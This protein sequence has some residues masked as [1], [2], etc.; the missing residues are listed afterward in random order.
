MVSRQ[1]LLRPDFS[2][3]VVTE[4]VQAPTDW[5]FREAHHTVVVHLAGQLQQME[6]VFS[7]GPSTDM[8]P[9]VGDCWVIPAG[10][11]YAALARGDQVSFVEFH[12][13]ADL[14]NAGEPRA[15]VGHRDAFLHQASLRLASLA[16]RT[17]DMGLMMQQ[18]LLDTLRLHL[19]DVLLCAGPSAP[20]RP[21]AQTFSAR[22]KGLLSDYIEAHVGG[23]ITVEALAAVT[24]QSMARFLE[25]FKTSFGTTPWQYVLRFRLAR[26]QHLLTSSSASI[27]A[28]ASAVGF[29][30]PSHFATAF[31]RLLGVS[32]AQ[33]RS[34][35][36]AE[37]VPRR[38]PDP[39]DGEKEGH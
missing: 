24:G 37:S 8:L 30:S 34:G 20:P 27:T 5:C 10:C 26:G 3:H 17:D 39:R 16:Q 38:L 2:A 36:V 13:P 25:C 9:A 31:S 29:S 4:D 21:S 35:R 12:I 14:P 15:R 23:T 18:A 11:Q 1:Q 32:P 7:V 6:S 19:A 22:Q 28:I 33:Y